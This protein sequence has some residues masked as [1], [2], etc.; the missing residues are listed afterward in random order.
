MH[1]SWADSFKYIDADAGEALHTLAKHMSNPAPN[2]HDLVLEESEEL[3]PLINEVN[4][5]L[6]TGEA[7]G[8]SG[9]NLVQEMQVIIDAC[10][11]FQTKS[12][13]AKLKE[14]LKPFTDSLGELALAIQGF[15][16]TE[17]AV[18]NHDSEAGVCKLHDSSTCL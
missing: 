16:E 6:Q 3:Q 17:L 12:K 18:A 5:K 7:L 1:R 11:E 14:E 13:N 8:E 4:R 15:T 2:E 10:K 9:S